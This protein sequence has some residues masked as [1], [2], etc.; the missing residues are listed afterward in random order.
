MK[1]AFRILVT[2]LVALAAIIAG[3]YWF[4]PI[5]LS[6]YAARKL[7]PIARVVPTELKDQ[8]VSQASGMRLSYVGYDFEVPWSDLD[9]SKTE[10]YPKDKAEKTAAAL[11]F[12]SGLRLT[13]KALPN[14]EFASL[15][16]TEFNVPPEGFE[17]V[18][19]RGTATS[20]YTFVRNVYE[21]TPDRMHYWS[22]RPGVHIREQMVLITKSMMTMR[23]AN[24]GI[25]NLRNNDYRGF[26][27]GT[28]QGGRDTVVVDL[29]SNDDHF[30][31]VF[32]Q[33]DYRNPA[34]VTQPEINRIV[35]SVHK[36]RSR[37][38]ATSAK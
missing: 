20:D 22:L 38:V 29:Y 36:T 34:G 28:P 26:Q 7:P 13:V 25:F 11:V 30:E 6:F 35:Q 4:T 5:G 1:R 16:A 37:E 3:L 27:Q 18:F 32:L 21:A 17:A 10:L 31:I 12:R 2:V 19:G 33:K 15:W 24:S 9:E 23:A 8:S 14:R